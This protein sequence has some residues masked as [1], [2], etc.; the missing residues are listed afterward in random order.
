MI[1]N[2][3]FGYIAAVFLGIFCIH[4]INIKLKKDYD[5]ATKTYTYES[6]Q[7]TAFQ[8]DKI[9][10]IFKQIQQNLRT[11]SFLPSVRNIDRHGTNLDLN[12]SESIQQIY[13]NLRTNVEVSE[14]YIVPVDLEP[15]QVDPVTQELQ[16]PILMFDK[17]IM[18]PEDRKIEEESNIPAIEIFEYHALKEQ[19]KWFKQH[20]SKISS[21]DK[22]KPPII[23]SK[24][25]ITC[26]NSYFLFSR[27][28]PDRSGI[29]FSIPF[30]SFE[31]DLKGT[32]ST[33]IL[34]KNFKKILE[35]DE[36]ALYN[37]E[38]NYF[39]SKDN[40][41][42]KD[43]AIKILNDQNFD[44]LIYSEKIKIDINN[45]TAWYLW[46]GKNNK[47]FLNGV[48]IKSIKTFKVASYLIVIIISLSI[49]SLIFLFSRRAAESVRNK[50]ELENIVSQRTK[51]VEDLIKKDKLHQ[52]EMEIQKK[53]LLTNIAMGIE[54]SVETLVNQIIT[55]ASKT[56]H[57]TE[58]SVN[59]INKNLE[60]SE[61]IS[62][63][64]QAAINNAAGIVE[65]S[66]NLTTFINEINNLSKN[67]ENDVN[68]ASLKVKEAK[69]SID[70]LYE[71]SEKINQI[72]SMISAISKQIKLL[73]L[74]A[75]IES[76]RAGEAG[77]GFA[78]V[79]NEVKT[80]SGEVAKASSEID[81]QI[82]DIKS[83]V[84]LSVNAVSD[85]YD[86]INKV[87]NNFKNIS[88]FVAQQTEATSDIINNIKI[89]GQATQHISENIMVIKSSA[90]ES[91]ITS[92]T[93]LNTVKE[94][95]QKVNNLRNKIKEFINKIRDVS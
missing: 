74:N 71:R 3:L 36:Y 39:I 2:Y 35:S 47:D 46:A 55:G 26:D 94:L 61:Q 18:S 62:E 7:A 63:S 89:S 31:G 12:A 66:K 4:F 38:T 90:Q 67:S 58:I 9:E 86:T 28:D 85:V 19:M 29:I 37:P 87:N 72:I 83:S 60:F 52:E 69:S 57:S 42:A 70:L 79:A 81:R 75:T 77:R 27:N 54:E 10:N 64:I 68:T 53:E 50:Q 15:D 25:L 51:E 14:V 20:Y 6:S 23:S 91:K 24:E 13:N 41:L 8:K 17:L 40:G 32:I 59:S 30:Y 16:A 73:A 43:N 5:L 82:H 88:T 33:I 1:K 11:I 93:V 21:I 80:L 76:A 95:S 84:K 45:K 48:S 44:E 22:I 56:E 92:I 34:T 78:V 49:I 65:S